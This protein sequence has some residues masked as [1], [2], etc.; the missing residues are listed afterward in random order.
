M[1]T[2]RDLQ[3]V[4]ADAVRGHGSIEALERQLRV[5]PDRA[6]GR[7]AVYADAYVSR[8]G[9]VVADDYPKVAVVLG[10]R[11]A[12]TVRDY[13][14]LHPSD[15][16]SLRHFGRHFPAF[17]GTAGPPDVPPWLA[18]LA[19]LEW[20][21]I[22]AFDAADHPT[23]S[24]EQ[25][26]SLPSDAWPDLRLKPV[27][28]FRTLELAWNVTDVWLALDEQRPT[29][30]IESELTLVAVW[31]AGFA[32]RHR[33]C[34]SP[35]ARAVARLVASAPFAAICEAFADSSCVGIDD[36][37]ERAFL[38]LRQWLADGWVATPAPSFV[39]PHGV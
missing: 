39:D 16:P 19:R 28:S 15:H 34:A 18:D 27:A 13:V 7:V 5:A 3:R 4:F 36:A 17:L 24:F 14:R 1:T 11:F 25:V 30:A 8:L 20:A 26:Q 21:R 35:E 2:L 29:P 22:E 9:D 32:V 38:A 31:R 12:A 23:L 10:P 37:A 6:R 33:C